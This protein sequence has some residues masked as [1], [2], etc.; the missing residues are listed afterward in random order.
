MLVYSNTDEADVGRIKVGKQA[1]F[2]VDS[3]PRE[4]FNGTVSQVRMN[5]TTIQNVVTYNTMIAFD[6]LDLRL[7]PGM[8][9]YISIPVAEA[10]NVVEIPNGALRFKP[11]LT[12]SER[13]ALYAKYGITDSA[14]ATAAGRIAGT[15]GDGAA[16]ASSG[17]A[18]AASGSADGQTPGAQGGQGGPGAGGRRGQGGSGA[19]GNSKRQDT[20]IVWKLLPNK[21]LEPVQVNLGVTDFTFTALVNGNVSPGDDLIIGQST[22]KSSVSQAQAR[23]PVTGAGNAPGVPRR[24]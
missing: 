7:F 15:V 24:F 1:T 4:T 9:A 14:R 10:K 16:A 11:D 21:T 18:T 8:T 3:F 12:D 17:G 13:T 23:N 19:G 2:R 22:N 5:A 20:A 6:N